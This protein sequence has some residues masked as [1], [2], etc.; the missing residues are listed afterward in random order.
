MILDIGPNSIFINLIL[1]DMKYYLIKNKFQ[2]FKNFKI[3]L[4]NESFY[5]KK[6]EKKFSVL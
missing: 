4:F 3:I 6:E 5:K 1:N 2:N